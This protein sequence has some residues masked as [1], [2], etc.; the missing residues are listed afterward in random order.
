MIRRREDFATGSVIETD[1]VVVGG[2]PIGIVTA[3]ELAKAGVRVALIESGLEHQDPVTQDLA[4]P[5]SPQNDYFHL[6]SGVS[7]RRQ[8]GGTTALWGGRCVKFDPV[9]FEDRRIT[10]HAPWPINYDD[11]EPYWQRACD[12]AVCGRAAFNAREIPEI[13]HRD[14]VTGLPDD[15]VRTSDLE[16]WS[17]PTRFGRTYASALRDVSGPE[18]WT[19]LTCVEIVTTD[20]GDRVDHLVVKTLDGRVGTVVATEYVIA[21]GGLE[22]T[23]L[24]LVSDRRHPGGLGNAGGHLGHWYMSHV[25][26]RVAVAQFADDSVIHAHE[27]DSEGVYVRRRFT[28]SPQLQR[29]LGMPNAAVWLVNP[30]ISNPEH[31]SGA[32][33]GVYL[34][35]I[36]PIGRFLLAQAIREQHIETGLA[37]QIGA[38]LCNVLRDLLPSMGFAVTFCYA[39][40][41]RR[42]R[43]APGFVVRSPDNRYLLQYH[44]EHLP[45]WASRVELSSERDALGMRR[46]CTHM[47]FT[48]AD[49]EGVRRALGQVDAHLREHAVG[50]VEWL[51][52]DVEELIHRDLKLVGG[53]HQVGTTRMSETPDGGVVDR[54]LEVHGVK[55][56]YVAST[57]VF[58]TSG[59][60]NPTLLGIALGLRLADRLVAARNGQFSVDRTVTPIHRRGGPPH[61]AGASAVS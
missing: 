28:F 40:F 57:S 46:I 52:D 3:L 29:R 42:G 23:R 7:V 4:V 49:Y 16:R 21:A 25:V 51:S 18:V 41:L 20:E 39:R 61:S 59:Q 55:G 33:S 47:C 26:C 34:A 44:G 48:E 58:P 24:L 11:V 31:R 6:R 50:H 9:D 10:A 17:L 35:L 22:A 56:L 19:G 38:H 30:P 14:M 45:H 27:R 13:A 1:V 54:N 43:K 60:A 8:L 32:L 53:L 2:G 12:W 5:A 36:S 37:P 15:A